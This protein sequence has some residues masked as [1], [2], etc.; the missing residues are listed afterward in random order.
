MSCIKHQGKITGPGF[1]VHCRI[2]RLY[3]ERTTAL[4][5]L[6]RVYWAI[7]YRESW[8]PGETEGE[9]LDR[10]LDVLANHDL[11]PGVEKDAERVRVVLGE[12]W[13][14]DHLP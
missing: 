12:A 13:R 11:D 2:E 10:A 7:R 8:H 4:H 5:A 14:G 9:T 3:R 6:L 1:C